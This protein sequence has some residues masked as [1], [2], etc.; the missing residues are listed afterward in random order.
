MSGWLAGLDAFIVGLAYL[1]ALLATRFVVR[2]LLVSILGSA[3]LIG[4]WLVSNVDSG[5]SAFERAI[6]PAAEA[7]MGTLTNAWDW[8][9][10]QAKGLLADVAA[11]ADAVYLGLW[12]LATVTLPHAIGLAVQQAEATARDLLAVAEADLNS[13]SATLSARLDAAA[14][15]LEGLI[16]NAR[17]EAQEEVSAAE[18]IVLDEVRKAEQTAGQL[19]QQAEYDAGQLVAA[20]ESKVVQLVALARQDLGAAV[21]AVEHD[22]QQLA[23][24]ERVLIEDTTSIL[25]GDIQAAEARAQQAIGALEAETQKTIEGILSGLPW[26]SLAAAVGAGE[27]VLQ[28]DVRTLVG[29]GAQEIRKALGDAEAIRAKYGPQVQAALQQ[30]RQA[31]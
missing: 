13:L 26:Q 1:G 10:G 18:R 27:A 23:K 8:L 15:I 20:S 4:G 9:T 24:A 7:S 30:L 28:A 2:P 19:W 21:G 14:Q 11:L 17:R 31:G 5:L 22:L 25:G 6:T 16:A 12:Q 3:P 29:L